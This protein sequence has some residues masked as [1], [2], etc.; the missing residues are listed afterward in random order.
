[1]SIRTSHP[2]ED[3]SLLEPARGWAA[4]GEIRGEGRAGRSLFSCFGQFGSS[5]P[6]R[7]LISRYVIWIYNKRNKIECNDEMGNLVDFDQ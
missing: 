3:E 1:M 4:R 6:K 7:I 2:S 5:L